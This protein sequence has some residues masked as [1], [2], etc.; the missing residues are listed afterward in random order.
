MIQLCGSL[1]QEHL[2]ELVAMYDDIA[3]RVQMFAEQHKVDMDREQLQEHAK[4]NFGQPF[5]S[6]ATNGQTTQTQIK[7]FFDDFVSSRLNIIAA[8]YI[9]GNP[10]PTVISLNYD[11]LAIGLRALMA[12]AYDASP[13]WTSYGIGFANAA[14]PM[15]GKPLSDIQSSESFID[16]IIGSIFFLSISQSLTK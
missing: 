1:P 8:E 5:Q 3:G 15:V 14:N 7:N 12:L 16:L 11:E 13:L 6:P 2:A 4:D 10:N 9:G